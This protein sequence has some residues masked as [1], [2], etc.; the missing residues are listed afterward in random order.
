MNLLKKHCCFLLAFVI[1]FPFYA[2]DRNNIEHLLESEAFGKERSIRVFLPER[3]F[4]DSTSSFMVTYVLDAQSDQFWNMAKSNIGYLVRSRCVIPT[5]AVGIVTESRGSE[6]EPPAESL[7]QHFQE[8]V[9]PLIAEKYRVNDFKAIIG[10]SWGGAF[11][12]NTLFGAHRDLFDA[13]IGVSPSMGYRYNMILNKGDSLLQAGTV[14]NKFFYCSTGDV[15]NLEKE[16]GEQVAFLDSLIPNYPNSN[17]VWSSSKF[18]GKD[19]WSVVIPSVNDALVNM[20]RN[21]WADQKRIE[22]FAQNLGKTIREQVEAF[23]A[24]KQATF[25]FHHPSNAR[26]LRFVGDDFRERGEH[27]IALEI[28]DWALD[29]NPREVR[30]YWSLGDIYKKQEK[31]DKVLEVYEKSLG[32]MHEQKAGFEEKFY[33]DVVEWLEKEISGLK[34]D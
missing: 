3:Y 34:E 29:L 11:V 26:Y 16:F 19:H 20:S 18:E 25:G 2:Q 30:I 21:Y 17:L 10:H 31:M 15:G 12:S 22:I 24:E 7:T 4:T 23:N 1:A 27:E 6:F 28:Y 5:I 14:F 33:N 9:F 32:L 8:E 13:Y